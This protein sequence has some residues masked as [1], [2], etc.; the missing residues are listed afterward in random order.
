MTLL[1]DLHTGMLLA[2]RARYLSTSFWLVISVLG[3]ALM[4]AQFSGRQP[5][6][7]ALD[8]GIS[9]IR[10]LL[11]LLIILLVQE[12]LS[13][14]FDRRYFLTSLSYP[15]PRYSLL[16][17]RLATVLLLVYAVLLVTGI[18]LAWLT[19]RTAM[20]Y[21]QATPVDLGNPYWITLAFIA[22]DLF[23]LASVAGLLAVV[24]STPSF[25]LIGTMGF[26]LISRSYSTII[27]LL[28]K[29]RYL[30]DNT[31][32]YQQSLG[33]LNYLLPNLAALDVRMITL[34]GKL[35]LLPTN[36][37]TSLIASLAY[38]TAMV[39]ITLLSLH[40]KRFS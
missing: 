29:D 13:R 14:E 31:D 30:L 8:V 6:T 2:R 10:L 32:L 38:G 18:A 5:A 12:L 15:R 9:A 19:A 40:R 20:G 33:V 36:W 25:V 28:E 26:M 37:G 22:I 17:A 7:V 11:P 23:V 34:Y 21:E 4:A 27:A 39:A 35:D 3:L 1:P 24:A 16:L